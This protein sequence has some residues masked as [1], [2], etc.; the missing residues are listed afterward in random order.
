MKSFFYR[1]CIK[2]Y[3]RHW[4]SKR[5]NNKVYGG[6][7]D[8]DSLK[9]SS[10][11]NLDIEVPKSPCNPERETKLDAAR[12]ELPV[13]ETQQAQKTSLGCVKRKLQQKIHQNAK[14]HKYRLQ[15][16]MWKS[17]C[18]EN[19]L[20]VHIKLCNLEQNTENLC[21]GGPSYTQCSGFTKNQ[22]T[23]WTVDKKAVSK[24]V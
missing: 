4:L 5:R 7:W 21:P 6:R 9:L 23:C 22:K 8:I 13:C 14:K 18:K 19:G 15:M 12:Q 2:T 10:E 24:V 17:I 16:F 11:D 1:L 20:T 3:R